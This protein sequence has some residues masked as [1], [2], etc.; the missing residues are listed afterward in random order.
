MQAVLRVVPEVCLAAREE[1]VQPRD[2]VDQHDRHQ[3]AQAAAREVKVRQR[4]IYGDAGAS[5]S[6]YD[7]LLQSFGGIAEDLRVLK[8]DTDRREEKFAYLNQVW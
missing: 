3:E 5:K 6:E 2:E 1:D 4:V 8:A 7:A